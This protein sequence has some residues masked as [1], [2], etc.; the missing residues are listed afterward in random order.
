MDEDVEMS[1]NSDSYHETVQQL[2][3]ERFGSENQDSQHKNKHGEGASSRSNYN[4]GDEE[5][6]ETEDDLGLNQERITRSAAIRSV[7]SPLSSAEVSQEF[8]LFGPIASNTHKSV[9]R[10]SHAFGFGSDASFETW[11]D[12]DGFKPFYDELQEALRNFSGSVDTTKKSRQGPRLMAVQKAITAGESYGKQRYSRR[13]G[14]ITK[15]FSELDFYALCVF[16]IVD[17]NTVNCNG[18][19]F[20]KKVSVPDMQCDGRTLRILHAETAK[21]SLLQRQATVWTLTMVRQE[22]WRKLKYRRRFDE[23]GSDGNSEL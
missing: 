8:G 12:G 2:K 7:A 23:H 1:D 11:L 15:D 3:R 13:S 14:P 16:E 18:A 20:S 22:K 4:N 17:F 9:T 10:L 19:F 21:N 5:N 6:S